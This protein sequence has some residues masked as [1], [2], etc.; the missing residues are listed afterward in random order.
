MRTE[1]EFRSCVIYSRDHNDF[2]NTGILC[3]CG[4]LVLVLFLLSAL[5]ASISVQL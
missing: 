3:L 4:F 2:K 5:P 1:A